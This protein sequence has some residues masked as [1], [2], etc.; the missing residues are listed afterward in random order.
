M[1]TIHISWIPSIPRYQ[2]LR[3]RVFVVDGG[4][5]DKSSSQRDVRIAFGAGRPMFSDAVVACLCNIL[6]ARPLGTD[7][8]CRRCNECMWENTW[9][10]ESQDFFHLVIRTLRAMNVFKRMIIHRQ[11]SLLVRL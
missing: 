7:A 3:R 8:W 5:L 11:V 9:Q 2:R 6:A 10:D 1:V 4:P